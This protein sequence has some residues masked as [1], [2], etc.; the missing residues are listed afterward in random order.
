M[1]SVEYLNSDIVDEKGWDIDDDALFEKANSADLD[2]SDYGVLEVDQGESILETAEEVGFE[3][4]FSC[5]EGECA[6]C[7]AHL[8]EGD[9]EM[10]EQEVISDQEIEDKN[11]RLTC[12]GTPTEEHVKIIYN[13]KRLSLDWYKYRY[14]SKDF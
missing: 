2:E 14:D 13:A 5:R 10:G 4:P 3:W 8:I 7:A 1:P 9:I 12:V 11:V 6:V